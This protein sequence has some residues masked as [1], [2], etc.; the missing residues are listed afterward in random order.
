MTPSQL[1][2]EL[3]DDPAG[4]GYAALVAAGN[5]AALAALLNAPGAGSVNR[6]EVPRGEL[7]EALAGT[8]GLAAVYAAAVD[9][10]GAAFSVAKAATLILDDPLGTVDYTR[11]G[12]RALVAALGPG[13]LAVLTAQQL[14]ALQGVCAKSGSRA[15]VLWG[16]GA[17]VSAQQVGEARNS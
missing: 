6:R 4:L 5:D 14:A 17:T 16:D 11:A 12:T 8:G 15:E 1:K 13:A 9:P 10:Q 3:T 7:L 2:A